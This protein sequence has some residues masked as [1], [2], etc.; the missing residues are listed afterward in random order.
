[1]S[2]NEEKVTGNFS[3]TTDEILQWTACKWGA[4]EDFVRAQA[5]QESWWRQ[6]QLGDCQ[7]GSVP[8]TNGCQTVG[9]LQVKGAN[10]PPTHPGTWPYA[11]QST[12]FNADYT[13][14]VWRACFEGKETWLGNGYS[15]GDAWG[16]IGRWFSGDWYG[17]SQNYINSVKSHLANK[18]WAQSGF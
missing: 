5:V 15:A 8:Q 16:C 1:L 12:A 7:G 14:A 13:L 2:L 9:I 17:N 10:L 11:Y 18:T 4:D 3:G 6:S